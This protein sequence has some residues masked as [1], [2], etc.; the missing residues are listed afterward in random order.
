[1]HS[2]VFSDTVFYDDFSLEET[3]QSFESFKAKDSEANMV[4]F[5]TCTDEGCLLWIPQI[6]SI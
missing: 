5:V 4:L 6:L 3:F 2:S 1:M